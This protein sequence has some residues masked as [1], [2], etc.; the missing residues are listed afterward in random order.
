MTDDR[1]GL[2]PRGYDTHIERGEDGTPRRLTFSRGGRMEDE[3]KGKQPCGF[4]STDGLTASEW[5]MRTAAAERERDEAVKERDKSD[6]DFNTAKAGCAALTAAP[7]LH[8]SLEKTRRAR[9]EHGTSKHEE[10][11]DER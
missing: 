7:L 4:K 10:P 11:T 1:P 3:A 5:V 9:G 8:R 2:M 6:V